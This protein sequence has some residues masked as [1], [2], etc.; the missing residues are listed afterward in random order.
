MLPSTSIGS[1]AGDASRRQD[2]W[3]FGDG[4]TDVHANSARFDHTFPGPGTYAVKATVFDNLGTP[5]A[6]C[7]R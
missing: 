6:G 5:T 2:R 1:S 7:S 4:T 3:D